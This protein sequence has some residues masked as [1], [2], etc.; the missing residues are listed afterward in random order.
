MTKW[1]TVVDSE[2]IVCQSWSDFCL[3][4]KQVK[5]TIQL[6]EEKATAGKVVAAVQEELPRL[7][8]E[9]KNFLNDN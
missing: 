7:E 2:I 1:S 5:N 6:T 9:E 8:V 4:G 3:S